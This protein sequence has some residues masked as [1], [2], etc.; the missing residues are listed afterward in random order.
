MIAGPYR[1]SARPLP[2]KIRCCGLC[3]PAIGGCP[4]EI[5]FHIS[6]WKGGALPAGVSRRAPQGTQPMVSNDGGATWREEGTA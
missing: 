1:T 6:K 4:R 2:E 5:V 3:D